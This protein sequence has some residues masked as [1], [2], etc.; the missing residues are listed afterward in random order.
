MPDN[1]L[2]DISDLAAGLE[3]GETEL[4][5]LD[6]SLNKLND[7]GQEALARYIRG[8]QSPLRLILE[9]SCHQ[10]RQV[11]FEAIATNPNISATAHMFQ[12]PMWGSHD[13]IPENL[14]LIRP[15]W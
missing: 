1:S 8:V 4:Q 13:S 12:R 6:L 3:A 7:A 15:R 5:L 9:E 2:D 11:V 14:K 10:L